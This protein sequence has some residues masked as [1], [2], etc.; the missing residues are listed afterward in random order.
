MLRQPGVW[1]SDWERQSQ[2]LTDPC[3][4]LERSGWG[5]GLL[6]CL[7]VEPGLQGAPGFVCVT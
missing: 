5:F 4:A 6:K 1:R 7:S 2:I 3:K